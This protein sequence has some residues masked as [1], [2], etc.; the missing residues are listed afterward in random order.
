MNKPVLSGS[1]AIT[2]A[3]TLF[4]VSVP[5][6]KSDSLKQAFSDSLKIEALLKKM[7]IEEKAG[8]LSLFLSYRSITTDLKKQIPGN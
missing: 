3:I 4:A 1:L 5:A 2:F 6:Q 8:Q 7:T